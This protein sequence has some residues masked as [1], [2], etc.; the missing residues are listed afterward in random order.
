[1]PVT[2]IYNCANSD[3][4]NSRRSGGIV[5]YAEMSGLTLENNMYYGE[6]DV[7]MCTMILKK[8]SVFP[9]W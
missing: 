6:N 1:M 5:S 7:M 2:E 3:I 4:F 9:K 8:V